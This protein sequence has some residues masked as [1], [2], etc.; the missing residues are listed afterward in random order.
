MGD[1]QGLFGPDQDELAYPVLHMV[2]ETTSQKHGSELSKAPMIPQMTVATDLTRSE[3]ELSLKP[4]YAAGDC[5]T[6]SELS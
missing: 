4:G 3:D 1:C 5:H 6:L 2:P